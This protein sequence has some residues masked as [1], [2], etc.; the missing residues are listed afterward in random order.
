MKINRIE[1]FTDAVVA[2]IM[3]IMV[4]EIK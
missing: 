4:L 2:I 3:T 1:A